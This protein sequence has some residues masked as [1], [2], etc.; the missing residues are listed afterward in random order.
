MGVP[1]D[2]K[3][4][5]DAFNL[6]RAQLKEENLKIWL[7]E[8][9]C[10][11][12]KSIIDN[13]SLY[14]DNPTLKVAMEAFREGTYT[15]LTTFDKNDAQIWEIINTK[16]LARVTMTNDPIDQICAEAQKEIEGLLK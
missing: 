3:N 14:A 12:L 13:E 2:A 8:T 9:V 15:G 1:K 7:E 5:E 4:K 10:V 11:P 16:V 6:I